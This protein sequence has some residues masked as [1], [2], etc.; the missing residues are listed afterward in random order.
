MSKVKKEVIEA[1]ALK[2]LSDITMTMPTTTYKFILGSIS[3]VAT[4][5]NGQII[6]DFLGSVS[7]AEGYVDLTTLKALI[8]GGFEASGGKISFDLFKNQSG[9]LSM[10]VKPI[11]LT[12]TKEDIS[13]IMVEVESHA[14]QDVSLQSKPEIQPQIQQH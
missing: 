11:T 13:K 9:L 10:F 2:L 6:H 8:N 5:N 1:A 14:I 12:I 7:D 4:M 3:A